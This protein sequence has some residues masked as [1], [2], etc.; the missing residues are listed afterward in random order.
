MMG[1]EVTMQGRIVKMQGHFF[2]DTESFDSMLEI[3]GFVP[4]EKVYVT[5][6]SRND[7]TEDNNKLRDRR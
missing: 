7:G 6:T 2:V 4:G 3:F 1:K 5:I